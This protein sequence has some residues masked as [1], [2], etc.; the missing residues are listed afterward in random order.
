M[1][2]L[3]EKTGYPTLFHYCCSWRSVCYKICVIRVATA[4]GIRGGHNFL[5]MSLNQLVYIS[6]YNIDDESPPEPNNFE[7]ALSTVH[8]VQDECVPSKAKAPRTPYDLLGVYDS[9][10]LICGRLRLCSCLH[11]LHL[12]TFMNSEAALL[13]TGIPSEAGQGHL[14]Q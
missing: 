11:I 3:N 2:V 12:P 6:N 1:Y 5:A 13:C 14:Q 4:C 10:T 8:K 9:M 7:S